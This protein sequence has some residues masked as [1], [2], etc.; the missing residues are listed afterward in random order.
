[1]EDDKYPNGATLS[2]HPP[3]PDACSL[4]PETLI[5]VRQIMLR[6]REIVWSC[7]F[8][9]Q[10]AYFVDEFGDELASSCF[11]Y[12]DGLSCGFQGRAIAHSVAGGA[13]AVDQVPSCS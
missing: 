8:L 2:V 3:S 7:W 9:G 6:H 5:Q 13:V 10:D 12:L 1:M 4:M 11:E